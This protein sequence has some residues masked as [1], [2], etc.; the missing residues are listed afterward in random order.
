MLKYFTISFGTPLML[1]MKRTMPIPA[2]A[3]MN[4]FIVVFISSRVSEHPKARKKLLRRKLYFR[5][6]LK[7][8]RNRL[9][10]PS[11]G[12]EY[13]AKRFKADPE[14]RHS[15]DMSPIRRS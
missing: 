13:E 4:I 6:A 15:T 1:R 11:N 5:T 8:K 10:L 2:I 14:Q 12:I 7:C 9:E 3:A